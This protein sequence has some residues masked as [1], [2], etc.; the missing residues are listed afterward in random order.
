MGKDN[1]EYERGNCHCCLKT[2]DV[3]WKNI[4]HAGSEGLLVCELCERKLLN[5]VR[6][7]RKDAYL[8]RFESNG[9]YKRG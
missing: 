9:K 8:E 7:L 6:N 2:T 5:F 3:R 1:Y 4:Y